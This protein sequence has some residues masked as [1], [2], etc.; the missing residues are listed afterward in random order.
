MAVETEE[1]WLRGN[2]RPV[3]AAGVVAVG[4][5]IVAAVAAAASGAA[6]T[7][8]WSLAAGAVGAAVLSVALVRAAS[9]LRV[10]RRG[11]ALLVRLSP[12]RV[13]E[14]PLTAVECV[15][16]GT[17]PLD[18]TVPGEDADDAG[19]SGPPSRRVVT[20][21]IRFAE[22]AAEWRERPTF[23]PWGTWR[24]GHAIIDGRWCEPLSAAVARSVGDRLL[25]AKRQA[26]AAVATR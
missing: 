2:V 22:R 25:E 13:E 3:I 26:A 12:G 15:F 17:L 8:A 11:G 4:G 21:V 20:L 14:V 23:A 18:G 6:P 5:G 10:G 1:V 9:G 19:P 7:V 16:P 24:D